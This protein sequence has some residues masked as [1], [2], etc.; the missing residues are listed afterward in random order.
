MASVRICCS[1]RPKSEINERCAFSRKVPSWANAVRTGSAEDRAT[2]SFDGVTGPI[3][4]R[5]CGLRWYGGKYLVRRRGAQ[6]A[7]GQQRYVYEGG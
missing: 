2:C 6:L 1:F 5:A 4:C 3:W 7:Y